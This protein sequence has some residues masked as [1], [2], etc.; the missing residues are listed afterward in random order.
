MI[1]HHGQLCGGT[2]YSVG[3]NLDKETDCPAEFSC[4]FY[5]SFPGE[6]HWACTS[7]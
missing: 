5:L 1:K 2:S 6:K 3:T 7:D 4:S